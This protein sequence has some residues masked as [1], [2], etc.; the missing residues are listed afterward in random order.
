[1]LIRRR[2]FMKKLSLYFLLFFLQFDLFAAEVVPQAIHRRARD[3]YYFMKEPVARKRDPYPWEK[4]GEQT[5]S[6][7]TKEYFRC[8]GNSLN[9]PKTGEDKSSP[10]TD[11]EGGKKHSLSIIHG[12]EGVYP[13]LL[14]LLNYV[15]KQTQKKVV[16][17][18]GHRCQRHNAYAD[19]SK[20]NAYSKHMIG[21][22]VDFYVQGLEN[23]PQK[24]I[25][26]IQE[27]YR[28]DPLLKKQNDWIVFSRYL[29]KDLN[30]STPAWYNKEIFIKLYKKNEGRDFDNRHPFPYI[31]LQV[32]YDRDLKE[33]VAYSWEK[34]N[35]AR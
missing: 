34:A 12:K 2:N 17:T 31:G 9:P 3:F 20:E 35:G 13:I 18:C 24:V 27:F 15:Q 8:P 4:E 22:E 21:A 33:K 25:D 11:C 23:E 10:I 29:N 30:V 32:R 6:K 26:L 1:M 5:F 7:I 16:I 14:D 28:Q 19:P